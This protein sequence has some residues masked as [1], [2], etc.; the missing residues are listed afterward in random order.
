M[1]SSD[2]FTRIL[3][4][5]PILQ[6]ADPRMKQDF[7]RIAYYAQIPGGRDIFTE[8]SDVDAI[9]LLISGTVRVYKISDTGR[10]ITLYRFSGGESCI[11][12]AN[13]ILND[14]SFSAIATIE[15]DAEAIMIPADTFRVWVNQYEI[16]RDFVFD[17]LSQ[18]LSHVME[19]VEEVAFGRMDVRVATF[20]LDRSKTQNPLITTHHEIAAELG[21][22]RE[23]ISRI[24]ASLANTHM[25]QV[26]R[27]A[28]EILDYESL[29]SYTL[30]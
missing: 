3:K 2:Q 17:L 13:A 25:I 29:Q 21:S 1:L 11:L 27:G 8:G 4:I 5:L 12:T 9:A 23:V 19:I 15:D 20:L 14:Q 24:L 28:I 16:W 18:R 26:K 30:R 22:S 6:Q 7:Q 10:E